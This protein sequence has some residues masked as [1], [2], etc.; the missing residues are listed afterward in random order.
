MGAALEESLKTRA[1]AIGLDV[2][3]KDTLG[4]HRSHAK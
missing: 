3:P 2:G 4:V 1:K